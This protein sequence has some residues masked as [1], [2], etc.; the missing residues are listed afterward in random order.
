M[1]TGAPD[2]VH[3]LLIDIGFLALEP[4]L[5][6]TLVVLAAPLDHSEVRVELLV[7]EGLPRREVPYGIRGR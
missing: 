5:P 4:R 6:A 7:I 1:V 3:L 2:E